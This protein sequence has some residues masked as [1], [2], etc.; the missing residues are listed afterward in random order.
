MA[1]CS[2]GALRNQLLPNAAESTE[3]GIENRTITHSRPYGR[4]WVIDFVVAQVL[5]YASRVGNLKNLKYG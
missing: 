5:L 4:L 2:G 3:A 1:Q